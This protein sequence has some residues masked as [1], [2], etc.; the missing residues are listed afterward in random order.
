MNISGKIMANAILLITGL[1]CP[2]QQN[3]VVY[4]LTQGQQSESWGT[5]KAETYN[6]AIQMKEP[7]LVGK[8]IVGLRMPVAT[9]EGISNITGWLTEKLD[10][11]GKND[12]P[13]VGSASATFSD[14]CL[15]VTFAEPY[16]IGADGLYAGYTFTV[17]Q[18]LSDETK[19]P[20]YALTKGCEGGM[21]VHSSRT[22][23]KWISL[24]DKNT[25][26]IRVIV[27]GDFHQYD[28]MVTDAGVGYAQMEEATTILVTVSGYGMEPIE[29]LRFAYTVDGTTK[30]ADV[31][32][33]S[34]LPAIYGQKQR[35]YVPLEGV[36]KAG[37]YTVDLAIAEINSRPNA[38]AVHTFSTVLNVM[39]FLPVTRPLMEEY[40]GLWCGYCPRGY[41]A[42]ERMKE[43][44]P[45]RFVAVSIHMGQGT[46][47]DPMQFLTETPNEPSGF[48]GAIMNRSMETDPWYGPGLTYEFGIND[49]WKSL[50]EEFSIADI[51]V[52]LAWKDESH[53]QIVCTSHSRFT[54]EPTGRDYRVAYILVA[55]GLSNPA[56]AQSNYYTDSVDLYAGQADWEVFTKGKS[57]VTGLIFNDI[58]IAYKE[59]QGVAGSIPADAH[60]GVEYTHSYVYNYADIHNTKGENPILDTSKIRCVVVLL[61]AETGQFINC[62][63]S[64]YIGEKLQSSIEEL[65]PDHGTDV[66]KVTYYDMQGR[67]TARP[68]KGIFVR[69]SV[70]RN[71]KIQSEKIVL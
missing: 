38:S 66:L 43:L 2:A 37:T 18:P 68:E 4:S 59:Q 60:R 40:T 57:Y 36:A 22:Y 54:I 51:N 42:L 14:G 33:D 9:S 6:V 17:E 71:G 46:V 65:I 35:V 30:Y 69:V 8:K 63:Q 21:F 25:A 27:E 5:S 55:D 53:Q 62:N 28:A 1:T 67:Q 32:L 26:D 58:A 49:Y 45:D 3:Q 61:D 39:D 47:A 41:V 10:I 16:V 19:T 13:D 15:N 56:W 31:Q 7:G 50:C 48:P 34:P 44:H 20:I 29:N 24:E 52:D 23:R 12:T 70:L 64:S 11:D